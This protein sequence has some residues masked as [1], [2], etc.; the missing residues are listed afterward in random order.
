MNFITK[1]R[2]I[3]NKLL[4]FFQTELG[5]QFYVPGQNYFQDSYVDQE[6]LKAFLVKQGRTSEEIK[7]VCEALGKQLRSL[8]FS[9]DNEKGQATIGNNKKMYDVLRYGV[10]MQ[11][12][13]QE[14]KRNIPLIDFKQPESNLFCIAEE[15]TLKKQEKRRIDVVLYINGIPIVAIE[16]KSGQH[17]VAPAIQQHISNQKNEAGEPR[18]F[19]TIQLLIAANPE[20][21]RYGTVGTYAAAF[22]PWKGPKH[23]NF[24]DSFK[25]LCNK[26]RLLEIIHG[27]V[28]F[29]RATRKI[30][31]PHQYFAIQAAQKC[32]KKGQGGIIWHHQ[33][34]GKSLTM[35]WLA[36][37][38]LQNM[39]GFRVLIVVDRKALE[40]Q[41]QTFFHHANERVRITENIKDLFEKLRY[42][43]E[44]I[45]CTIVHKFDEE[46]SGM[47]S[48]PSYGE[49]RKH[50][51]RFC[52]F[53][54]E[55]HRSH[56]GF[57]HQVMKK[58][59]P[60]AVFIGFTGT[61]LL[62]RD[63]ARLTS[64]EV[65]GPYI[66]TYKYNEAVEDGVVVQLSYIDRYL[67]PKI[68]DAAAMDRLYEEQVSSSELN[69][70]QTEQYRKALVKKANIMQH[71]RRL[72]I[73]VSD[74]I[75]DMENSKGKTFSL[76]VGEVNA[77]L[78]VE[79]VKTAFKYYKKFV[80]RGFE[81]CAV[82]SSY[83]GTS[84]HKDREKII[85]V[86]EESPPEFKKQTYDEMLTDYTKRYP[87]IGKKPA[88]F[89][90]TIKEYF[91]NKPDEIK[92]L[93]LV[94]KLLTGFDAPPATYLYI[95]KKMRDHGLFQ[96]ICRVNR[97]YKIPNSTYEVKNHGYIIDYQDLFETL[98]T[99]IKAYTQGAFR[100]YNSEDVSGLLG[101][102]DEMAKAF[103]DQAREKLKAVM[104]RAPLQTE[105]GYLT[106][107]VGHDRT[108]VD[109][110]ANNKPLRTEFYRAVNRYKQAYVQ[111]KGLMEKF[112]TQEEATRIK[113]EVWDYQ[114]LLQYIKM[115]SGDKSLSSFDSSIDKLLREHIDFEHNK[116]ESMIDSVPLLE[117]IAQKGLEEVARMSNEQ[118][119]LNAE[120]L[121]D[122]IIHDVRK[123][124]QTERDKNLNKYGKISEAFAK[125]IA[126]GNIQH[127]TS[128]QKLESVIKQLVAGPSSSHYPQKLRTEGQRAMYDNIKASEKDEKVKQALRI[129]GVGAAA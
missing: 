49:Q 103:L 55:C 85:E 101:N 31:R 113:R 122:R 94:D 67:E 44:R 59:L 128:K 92:L 86:Q 22:L 117:L 80:Q 7:K 33:G 36:Q 28:C 27:F 56:S 3:Q 81:R 111:C 13:L 57:L 34:S 71:G 42:S 47:S 88:L 118:V 61:P 91:I 115:A 65:F 60:N 116:K 15:V 30:C 127:I 124:L 38:V 54:D 96:A 104:E 126:Q 39:A 72:D 64:K 108:N 18:F 6:Q 99:T 79:D 119:V 5:Y 109:E 12:T 8:D 41:L 25:A 11:T 100:A 48:T 24:L 82:I 75:S 68:K 52:V 89:E 84:I 2:E 76:K 90:E 97:P 95:D 63:K 46:R 21:I 110:V 105:E 66:H 129:H 114:K 87:K 107:F 123:K 50:H 78:A 29:D 45:L 58:N 37:W 40:Q 73:I 120:Q 93:I 70:K 16:L 43:K 125:L 4:A 26:K 74:I 112:Y 32:L 51:G 62:K 106:Y 14:K 20:Q 121:Y 23:Y 53:I 69:E 35:L 83:Q 98:E 10:N 19:S 9:G 102:R 77:I 17:A 1:E